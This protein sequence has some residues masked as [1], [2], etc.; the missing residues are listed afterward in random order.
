VSSQSVSE[1]LGDARRVARFSRRARVPTIL[2]IEA[3]ECGAAC[4]A[5]IL[6]YFGAWIPLEQLRSACGVS[7]DG[8]KATNVL[9]GARKYGLIAKGFKK[10]VD[11]LAELR[12]PLVVHWNFNHFVV[13]E[14]FGRGRA[15]LNDPAWGPR[16]ISIEEF[17]EG[18][19]GVALVFE[20]GPDFAK[21]DRPPGLIAALADRLRG[22]GEAFAFISL[23]SLALVLP[24]VVLPAFAKMFVDGIVLNHQERWLI[25]L[26]LAMALTAIMRA[27]LTLLQQRI[28][29]KLETKLAVVGAGIFVWHVIRMPM[30]FFTQRHAGEIANRVAAND[31]VAKLMSGDFSNTV[32][33]MGTALF[34]AIV[35]LTYDLPLAGVVIGLAVPNYFLMRAMRERMRQTSRRLLGEKGKVSAATI[36]IIHNIETIK[37]SGIETEAFERWSGYHATS[38]SAM[39]ELGAQSVPT[40]AIPS[41]LASLTNAAILGLGAWRVIGGAITIG[42]LVAFQTLAGSFAAPIAAFVALGSTTTAIRADLQRIGDALKNPVDR[43]VAAEDEPTRSVATLQGEVELVDIA[44]G[45]SALDPPLIEGVNLKLKPGMR[46]AFVGAS[47]SG[48]STLGRLI[49]GLL[50]PWAGQILFDGQPNTNISQATRAQSLAYVD[51]DIFL[52]AG[53]VSEN[54]TLWNRNVPEENVTRALADACM[55]DEVAVRPGQLE[56]W[57]EEGGRNFSGGQRQRLEIARALVGNP[58][59][60]VLD[61]ATASLDTTTEKLIDQNLR[62]R[63]CTCIIIAHRLSTIRDCDEI[64]LLRYGKAVERG[65]HEDLM[66][67]GG[68]YATLIQSA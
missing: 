22:S 39:R 34:F 40:S 15:W 44:F 48:K 12:W 61:E 55:L 36:G 4:L 14:G 28:L 2:Q 54:L 47:G 67:L 45:Y 57:V 19:T 17:D 10:E 18:F 42:D 38:L 51:Q 29:V 5:M 13:L 8:A 32:L 66:A 68:Q 3:V 49:C 33:Q 21:T 41:L 27:V 64:I 16:D 7:R 46:V 6:A 52:F 62:R 23:I 65:T 24:G 37:A 20:P 43:L 31:R 60:L 56:A 53:T 35:M 11:A 9:K 25:P 63:G 30:S 1:P 58:A 59:I 26:L 50:E